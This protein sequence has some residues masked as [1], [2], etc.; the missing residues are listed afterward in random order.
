MLLIILIGIVAAIWAFL[1]YVYSYWYRNGFDYIEPS[2]PAGN[3]G[4]LVK[5]EKSFGVAISDL[6]LETTKPFIGIYLTFRPVLLIRDAHMAKDILTKDFSSFHDR[7][8]YVDD[9]DPSSQNLFALQGHKWKSLRAKLTPT[10]TSGKLKNMFTSLEFAG[11]SMQTYLNSELPEKGY[12]ILEMKDVLTRYAADIIASSIFGIEVNSFTDPKNE[13]YMVRELANDPGIL[14]A[15]LTAAFFLCPSIVRVLKFFPI[16]DPVGSFM[17]KVV[18]QTIEY[19]EKNNY[20]RKDLMQSLIQLRN[21]G[22]INIDDTIWDVETAADELKSMSIDVCAAQASV[23]Y[24]AG[25]ETSAATTSFCLYELAQNEDILAKVQEDIKAALE[26]HNGEITYN[27]IQDMKY[28]DLCIKETIRKY[29]GL[30]ILNRECTEDFPI[31]KTDLVIKKGTGVIIPTLAMHRDAKY[32]PDP[33]K[34][35]PERFRDGTN[36]TAYLPFGEGP[37]HCIGMRMGKMN[38]QMGIVM[39]L[40]KFNIEAVEKKELEFDNYAV[41]LMPKGGINIKLSKK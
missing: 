41:G 39:I 4:S 40:T 8:I 24:M 30:P 10:F 2:I 9:N 7:G 3:L 26:N 23:F 25:L 5:R 13:F 11:K 22:K 14:N 38:A 21:T 1:K 32:F 31:P 15:L 12:K 20:V 35:D 18:K 36:H 6:Y 27:S 29:P 37:R 19:R 17:K 34:F 33:L 16:K 28:L